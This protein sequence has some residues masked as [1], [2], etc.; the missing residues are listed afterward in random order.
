MK[1]IYTFLALLTVT[2][3][4]IASS[5]H[6]IVIDGINNGWTTDETFTNCSSA[7]NAYFTWDAEYI[8]IGIK[9]TNADDELAT[10]IYFDT[11]PFGSNG[12]DDAYAWVDYIET[13][14]NTDWAIVWKNEWSNDYIE[15]K[16]YNGATWDSPYG[17]ANSTAL[18]YSE[19]VYVDF[20]VGLDYR[21]VRIKR[22]ALGNPDA[23]K[24]CMFSEYQGGSYWR[25]LTWP[26]DGWTD[27]NRA[28]GQSIP[29]YYGFILED[30]IA[31]ND[32]P[33]YNGDITGFTGAAKSTSWNNAGN[34]SENAVPDANSLVMLSAA[35]SIDVD[36]AAECYDMR[37][38][39]GGAFSINTDNSLTIHNNLY[40]YTGSS[41]VTVESTSSGNGS[42]IISGSVT[43]D[44]TADCY[45]T[46][47]Q[48]HSFTAPV[49]GLTAYELYLNA[50]PEVWLAEYDEATRDYTFI[51]EFTEP[52][53]DV[54]GWMLWVGGTGSNTYSFEGEVRTGTL[55]SDNNMV[56]SK[57][58]GTDD[59]GF[60][61]V[62]NPFTSAI[63]WDAASGW[64]KSANLNNAIYIFNN[65][66][67][68]TYINGAG[69]N[70]GSK[71]IAMNQGFFVQ[72]ADG[73]GPYDE[74]GTL[75][76]DNNVCVHNTVD[77][78]KETTSIDSLIRLQLG[79]SGLYDETVIRFL[80][81]A[82][83][84]FDGQWDAHKFFSYSENRPL[85]YS[86]TGGAM[87][88]NSLPLSIQE[89]QVS[90]SGIHGINMIISATEINSFTDVYLSDELTGDITNLVAD[91]YTFVY[92]SNY[93]DRFRMFFVITDTPVLIS[94]TQLFTAYASNNEIKVQ[95]NNDESYNILVT[96]LLGQQIIAEQSNQS[97][98]NIPV[99]NNG[100]FLITIQSGNKV[101]TSKIFVQ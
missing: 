13:P 4:A 20:A 38:T 48:W 24:V 100:I 79:Q 25:Y 52:I 36:A 40:N 62:G 64:S 72:V 74:Y 53:G 60:N 90:A 82:T 55:G 77:Y 99:S 5:N 94:D 95:V 97:Q 32:A 3:F 69:V 19:E 18:I 6:T 56:R 57:A 14:F 1:K 9:S 54:K 91:N 84:E 88:I 71:Y 70:E 16:Q 23:I 63:D 101:Q 92:D 29:N 35:A 22:S 47:G 31:Q 41:G 26:K 75:K 46:A 81:E 66:G 15:F 68:A 12:T 59:Y 34:W 49:S 44:I 78:L 42:L 98:L 37:I 89:V 73:G 50:S 96:N 86:T 43:G 33:Y 58:N 39:S 8:Y 45:I 61:Y 27:A 10:F 7:D 85:I 67:W 11:D 30:G 87:S 93:V 17:S 76:M 28:A 80:D 65:G 21:E 2:S 51:S 83:E